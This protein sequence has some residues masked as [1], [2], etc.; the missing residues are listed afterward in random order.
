MTQK[1]DKLRSH[2]S[3]M[4]IK[5]SGVATDEIISELFWCELSAG[6]VERRHE[7]VVEIVVASY[8][9]RINAFLEVISCLSLAS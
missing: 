1:Q 9:N 4:Y 2:I 5:L 8:A 7:V 6:R 3:K